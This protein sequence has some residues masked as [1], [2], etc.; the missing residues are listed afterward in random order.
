MVLASKVTD[1]FFGKLPDLPR[2]LPKAASQDTEDFTQFLGQSSDVVTEN[3]SPKYS[4]LFSCPD[5]P[6][7][8]RKMLSEA[9]EKLMAENPHLVDFNKMIK[10][11]G[12][13]FMIQ[14]PSRLP[15]NTNGVELVISLGDKVQ[16]RYVHITA[17]HRKKIGKYAKRIGKRQ[18]SKYVIWAG[19][20]MIIDLHFK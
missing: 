6:L 9:V 17:G 2:D 16:A 18:P 12:D 14:V 4:A 13:A 15:T 7:Y 3:A 10:V 11:V 1:P 8:T 5:W 19:R 20:K